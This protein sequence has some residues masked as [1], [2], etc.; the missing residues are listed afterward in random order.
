MFPPSRKDKLLGHLS[1]FVGHEPAMPL[2]LMEEGIMNSS[3]SEHDNNTNTDR[4]RGSSTIDSQLLVEWQGV[5]R[6]VYCSCGVLL[7]Y[8][9][10]HV[11]HPPP[12]AL[13]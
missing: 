9:F 10:G 2:H 4:V 13:F 5:E 6:C 11:F 3:P 12:S 7:C 1:L 8:V